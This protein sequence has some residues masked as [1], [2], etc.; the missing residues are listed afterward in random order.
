MSLEEAATL[1]D[2]FITSFQALFYQL[3]LPIPEE[4]PATTPPALAAVPIL[5]Y[6]AGSTNG[7]YAIQLLHSAGYKNVIAVA[8]QKHHQALKGWGAAHCFDYNSPTFIE[9]IN[10]AAGPEKVALA[11]DCIGAEATV[12]NIAKVMSPTGKVGFLLPIKEGDNVRGGEGSEMFMELPAKMN[13]FAKT[14]ETVGILTFAY[15]TVRHLL[16]LC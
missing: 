3:G 4:F 11:F 9:E 13:K 1:P 12:E 5:I 16:L 2:N 10:K 8:S 7:Q 15:Q 6:G 14:T